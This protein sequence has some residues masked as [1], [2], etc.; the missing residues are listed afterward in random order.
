MSEEAV[1]IQLGRVRHSLDLA[2]LLGL[3]IGFAWAEWRKTTDT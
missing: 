3:V 2:T 1:N